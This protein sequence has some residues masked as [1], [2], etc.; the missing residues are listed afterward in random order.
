MSFTDPLK[1]FLINMIT[2]PDFGVS[3]DIML[4]RRQFPQVVQ[5]E[6]W[7]LAWKYRSGALK[8]KT[9]KQVYFSCCLILLST[10]T[11]HRLKKNNFPCR[12]LSHRNLLFL[13]WITFSSLPLNGQLCWIFRKFLRN[14]F[15]GRLPSK[16]LRLYM[17]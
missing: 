5:V 13:L 8:Y 1:A 7:T 10:T 17:L 2:I 9:Y 15:G 4:S 6:L 16:K 3:T 11:S 14:T 12:N